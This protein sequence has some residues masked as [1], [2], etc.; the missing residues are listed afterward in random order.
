MERGFIHLSAK[1][2]FSNMAT[3]TG[4]GS[5]GVGR[6]HGLAICTGGI[7]D[8]CTGGTGDSL[9]VWGYK[10]RAGLSAGSLQ[11]ILVEFGERQCV[12]QT[13]D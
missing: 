13:L 11:P 12:Q 10:R 5:G 1:T 9:P 3:T 6:E 2:T 4:G 8:L 7:G